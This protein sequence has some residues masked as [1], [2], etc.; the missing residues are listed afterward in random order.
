MHK[1]ALHLIAYHL[2]RVSKS[3]GFCILQGSAAT[4]FM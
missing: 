1:S 3:Y 2:H 4:V